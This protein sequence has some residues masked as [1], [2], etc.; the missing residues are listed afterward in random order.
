MYSSSSTPNTGSQYSKQR[1]KR[2]KD[3][4]AWMT[5]HCDARAQRSYISRDKKSEAVQDGIHKLAKEV[6]GP[7]ALLFTDKTVEEVPALGMP[8]ARPGLLKGLDLHHLE[9][10]HTYH[11][12]QEVM[13]VHGATP[14]LFSYLRSANVIKTLSKVSPAISP[15]DWDV[16]R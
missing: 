9:A 2:Q 3:H 16:G 6:N 4:N 15:S 8:L 14:I 5:K 10:K 7:C 11:F 1:L 12:S 13:L